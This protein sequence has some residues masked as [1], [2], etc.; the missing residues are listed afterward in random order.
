[1]I[2][3]FFVPAIIATVGLPAW[4]LIVRR[5]DALSEDTRR[6]HPALVPIRLQ[7]QL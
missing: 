6:I 7:E 2:L 5:H 4:Q 3:V 1:M